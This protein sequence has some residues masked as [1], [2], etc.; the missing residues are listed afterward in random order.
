M[1]TGLR[2][3]LNPR[4]IIWAEVPFSILLVALCVM[5]PAAGSAQ[6]QT[7]PTSLLTEEEK[8]EQDFT[9]PL[10][11]LPQV[12]IRDSYSPADYGPCTPLGCPRNAETNQFTSSDRSSHAFRLTLC[13]H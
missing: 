12:V 2:W 9:D 11:A 10:T 7:A 13:F 4:F 1:R 8:L 5:A 3:S 6:A